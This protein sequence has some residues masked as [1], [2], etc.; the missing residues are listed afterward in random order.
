[1]SL[2][3]YLMMYGNVFIERCVVQEKYEYLLN[4]NVK[5]EEEIAVISSSLLALK[6]RL[7]CKPMYLYRVETRHALF[8]NHLHACTV[9]H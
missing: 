3:A 7:R 9:V 4:Q 6:V 1:M 8:V 2:M 5:L